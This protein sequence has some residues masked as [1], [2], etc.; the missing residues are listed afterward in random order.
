VD[1]AV[2]G[3]AKAVV[4]ITKGPTRKVIALNADGRAPMF[5]L[6]VG[7]L[8]PADAGPFLAGAMQRAPATVVI[9]GRGGRRPAFNLI[10]RIV[11]GER[12]WVVVSTPRSGWFT[13]AGE[14]GGGIAAWLELA[15]WGPA[16]LRDYNLAFLCNSGHEYEN[17]GAQESLRAAAPASAETAFWL[18]LGANV[19]ARDWHEGLFGLEP[20]SGADSQRYLVLSARLLPSARR[21]FA[22]F[23]GLE[24]PY[25]T[26]RFSAGELTAIIAA[27]YPSVA[28]V[29]GVHRF[30][31]VADDDARCAPADAI[32]AAALAFRQL[33]AEATAA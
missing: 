32:A 15:R 4:I 22:G 8:A 17:L 18:H 28:G 13:C 19:A 29:F 6:P 24:N 31:H 1:A 10:G 25:P 2:A 9:T 16:A 27:G 20:L 23:P 33:L 3:G 14:R 12:P 30:H 26:T 7:L 5:P 11:R 21:L